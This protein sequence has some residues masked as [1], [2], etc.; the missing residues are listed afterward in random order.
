[1]TQR[2]LGWSMG[3][4]IQK[5]ILPDENKRGTLKSSEQP[6]FLWG[7]GKITLIS[8]KIFT[9][10]TGRKWSAVP[11]CEAYNEHSGKSMGSLW[12]ITLT[13]L[14]QVRK[15]QMRGINLY[16]RGSPLYVKKWSL[17]S[18]S[19]FGRLIHTES[20]AHTVGTALFDWCKCS[21]RST[22]S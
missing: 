8:Y 17:R 1:M 9:P 22:M 16:L 11:L 10:L 6:G 5:Q 7:Q 21:H 2:K 4:A 18:R 13:N 19:R 20:R 14:N 3:F 12:W 15:P